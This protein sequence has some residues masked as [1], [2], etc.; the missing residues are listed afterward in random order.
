[1]VLNTEVKRPQPNRSAINQ[2]RLCDR[3][4]FVVAEDFVDRPL[5]QGLSLGH[6][7]KSVWSVNALGQDHARLKLAEQDFAFLARDAGLGQSPQESADGFGIVHAAAVLADSFDRGWLV[8]VGFRKAHGDGEQPGA[9]PR[10]LEHDG[11]YALHCSVEDSSGGKGE[12]WVRG[13]ASRTLDPV[14]RADATAASPYTPEE[15]YIV[16]VLSIDEAFMKQ[17][18]TDGYRV[19]VWTVNEAEDMERM[20]K[21]KVDAIIT[22]RPNILRQVMANM[23]Q[24]PAARRAI[25]IAFSMCSPKK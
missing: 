17:A 4:G 15:R 10:E 11:R 16:F 8:K 25:A 2:Q 1:M 23:G 20:L 9:R 12:F 6:D 18:K 24:R 14:D 13:R 3:R 7:Q 19:N 21:L 22:D 5:T